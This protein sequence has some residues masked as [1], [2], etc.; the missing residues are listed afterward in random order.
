MNDSDEVRPFRV[1]IPQADLDDLH[2]RLDRVRWPPE[3]AGAGWERGV[4]PAYLM[5]LVEYWRTSYGWRKHE[6][7]LN[8]HPQYRTAIDGQHVHFLQVR[9]PEPDA[10]PLLLI[11]GWPGSVVEFLDVIGPLSDPRGH[12][13]DPADAFHL[14]IPSIPGYGL[15]GPVT[16]I[17]WTDGRVAAAFVELMDRLGHD[18]YGVRGGGAGALIATLMGRAA[19][20]R[21]ALIGAEQA[22]RA[23]ARQDEETPSASTGIQDTRPLTVGY[24]LTDSPV[25]QLA[26]IADQL[27]D[28]AVSRDRLLTN[29]MLYWLTR[30]ASSS[31][32]S[33][34]DRFHDHATRA[35]M[36]REIDGDQFAALRAPDRFVADVRKFF[37]PLR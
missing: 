33:H 22:T 37:S 5:D 7:E 12:G 32:N 13:G 2:D 17:G 19:P 16:E 14:V 15:S 29:V 25:G 21:A 1:H 31:A 3:L 8:E 23:Q 4:P 24:G 35:R 34:Y 11:H 26:C 20:D 27:K 18:R 28:A 30:T 6:A 10:V 36:P 9:S